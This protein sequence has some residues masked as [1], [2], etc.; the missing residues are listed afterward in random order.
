MT[1]A[2]NTKH[3]LTV[4]LPNPEKMFIYYIEMSARQIIIKSNTLFLVLLLT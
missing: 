3:N 2:L 4:K 1:V